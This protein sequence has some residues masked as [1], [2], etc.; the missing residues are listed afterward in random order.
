MFNPIYQETGPGLKFNTAYS[1][2]TAEC[3]NAELKPLKIPLL[4]PY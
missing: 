4:I 3:N 2:H 1:I